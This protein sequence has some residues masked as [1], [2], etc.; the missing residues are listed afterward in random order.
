VNFRNEIHIFVNLRCAQL[1]NRSAILYAG[2]GITID[3]VPEQEL[4]ETDIKLTTL[5]DV[6]T[7]P[8]GN[9]YPY[10]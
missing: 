10:V 2:A 4:A 5:R 9:G 6:L 3:S 7:I 1:L 8:S